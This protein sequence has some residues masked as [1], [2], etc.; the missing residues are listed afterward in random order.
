MTQRSV[1][2]TSA[3]DAVLRMWYGRV[4]EKDGAY[5]RSVRFDDEGSAVAR[6]TLATGR[7]CLIARFGSTELACVNYYT[8]W[9]AGRAIPLA[10]PRQ[11]RESIRTCSGV[12]STDDASLDRFCEL[13]LD[14]VRHADVMGVWFNR[15]ED[16]IVE[17]YCP[18]ARLVYLEALNAVIRKD[19]W[20]AELAGKTVLVVHPFAKTIESQYRTRRALLFDNPDMLPEFEL[21]TL[22][23]VQSLAGNDGGYATW[24]DALDHMREQ[25]AAIE[26]DV[27]IIGAGAYGLP[28]AASVKDLGRQA[29]QL[30]GATQLLFG[31]RGRRWELESPD[32]VALVFNEHWVRP[33]AEE[34]PGGAEQ[35]EGGCYW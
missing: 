16:R 14:G 29:V 19:P 10:Y 2:A 15:N 32:E 18:D 28:L 13:Y 9:R 31:I 5:A 11:V 17:R 27:A 30:G 22:A 35:V 12:F 3:R 6:E 34:T 25:I 23:A 20:S 1:F 33:S 26:F 4:P 21:K 24:F 7:P 8:R